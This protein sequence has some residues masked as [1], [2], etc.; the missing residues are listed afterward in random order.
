MRSSIQLRRRSGVHA[1]SACFL[2]K[3]LTPA[4]YCGASLKID[5]NAKAEFFGKN[6]IMAERVPRL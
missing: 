5:K 4:C 1:F 6:L 3:W 2:K